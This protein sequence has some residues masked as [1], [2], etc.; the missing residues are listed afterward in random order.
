MKTYTEK[1]IKEAY[2][3]HIGYYKQPDRMLADLSLKN[4]LQYLEDE[5]RATKK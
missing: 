5:K 3:R 4:F 1:E 2:K